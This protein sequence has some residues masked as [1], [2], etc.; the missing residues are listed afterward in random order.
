MEKDIN[1]CFPFL[2]K[3]GKYYNIGK[4]DDPNNIE[5]SMIELKRLQLKIAQTIYN[6][7][8]N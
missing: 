1:K 7:E 4:R 6:E 3:Q 2:T 8:N 5:L